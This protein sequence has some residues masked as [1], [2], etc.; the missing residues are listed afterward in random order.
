MA[1]DLIDLQV[2]QYIR[3]PVLD[4]DPLAQAI[5]RQ[6]SPLLLSDDLGFGRIGRCIPFGRRDF[7]VQVGNIVD[8]ATTLPSLFSDTRSADAIISTLHALSEV[9]SKDWMTPANDIVPFLS[10]FLGVSSNERPIIPWP[11]SST[12]GPTHSAFRPFE[13]QLIA[14]MDKRTEPTTTGRVVLGLYQSLLRDVNGSN[15][16]WEEPQSSLRAE[17]EGFTPQAISSIYSAFREL[18]VLLSEN[19]IVR[20]SKYQDII[21]WHVLVLCNATNDVPANESSKMRKLFLALPELSE[22]IRTTWAL[23]REKDGF[24]QSKASNIPSTE[25]IEDAWFAMMLRAM[26]WQRLHMV[27]RTGASPLPSEFAESKFPVY[28]G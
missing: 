17:L 4:E 21:A 26:C 11:N 22:G 19:P 20:G 10:V 7:H 1:T 8:V 5:I 23:Q 18:E 14:F 27:V 16:L 28:I 24:E 6:T 15:Q 25:T 3:D 2:L 12:R 13:D 9:G